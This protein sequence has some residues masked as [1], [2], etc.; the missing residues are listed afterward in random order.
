[1][2]NQ[3]LHKFQLSKAALLWLA[4]LLSGLSSFS[5]TTNISGV[6]NSYYR[7][8]DFVPA[9]SCVRLTN[10]FGINPGD[11]M[12]LIQMKGASMNVPSPSTAAWGDT[13]AL[14]NAGNYEVAIVCMTIGD[15]VFFVHTLLN[16]YTPATGKVQLVKF[17]QYINANV[18]D[19]LRASPWS[20]VLGTG[21]VIALYA[22]DDL[23]LNR[24]IT[25]NRSGFVGGAFFQSNTTCSNGLSAYT[26]NATVAPGGVQNGAYKGECVADI[27]AAQNGGRAAPAN[28]GGGGNNHNNGGGGGANLARGGMGGGNSSNVSGGCNAAFR[29]EPGKALSSWGGKKIFL[30]GGGGAGHNNNAVFASSGGNGGGIVFIH[31]SNIIGNGYTISADGATGGN[32][33]SDGAGG[34]G[35]AGT[36]IMQAASYSNVT[37]QANGGAGGFSNDGGNIRRCYGSGGGGSGGAIYFNG[38]TPSGAGIAVTVDPGAGGLEFG[39]DVNCLPELPSV[40]GN[41]GQIINGYTFRI[42]TSLASYCSLVLPV[43]LTYF[44]ATVLEKKVDLQWNITQPDGVAFFEVQKMNTSN[45]WITFSTIY[46]S[47]LQRDYTVTDENTLPGYNSYRLKVT[48]KNNAAFYSLI[49]RVY[50]ESE[51]D[52]FIVYPNPAHTKLFIKANYNGFIDVRLLDVS[53][54]SVM[55]K[56]SMLN[57]LG[58]IDLPALPAGIYIL[59]I[60]N[61]VRKLVI[62]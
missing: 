51:N 42:G 43:R 6:I 31:A 53:G 26:Y 32:A 49:R 1:M 8:I 7:V 34:G 52:E 23:I 60:N 35:G 24:P 50:I 15:S 61:T 9:K 54:K 44:K 16:N 41:T 40:A 59:R 19:T 56:R 55:L 11:R 48:E 2:R 12:L 13:T 33:Q 45:E 21:G 30:G 5:Q 38:A 22:E 17:G 47:D 46:A 14:N 62:R 36:I 3:D 27:P 57:I 37:M 4:I 58:E 39:R 29:G 10:T 20:D 25:A 18:T 28:G